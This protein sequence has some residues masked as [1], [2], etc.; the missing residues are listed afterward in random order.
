MNNVKELIEE[1]RFQRDLEDFFV[2]VYESF[3]PEQ[4]EELDDVIDAI[5]EDEELTLEDQLEVIQQMVGEATSSAANR[6]NSNRK[7]VGFTSMFGGKSKS[8]ARKPI[9]TKFKARDYKNA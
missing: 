9:N 2:E 6:A 5:L 4:H 7:P 3:E 1:L 8:V